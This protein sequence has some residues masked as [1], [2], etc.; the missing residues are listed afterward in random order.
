MSNNELSIIAITPNLGIEIKRQEIKKRV[1]DRLTELNLLDQKFKNNADILLLVCNLV[2]FM[3]KDKK[4]NKK[5]I[6][7]DIITTVYNN[8]NERALYD[9]NIEF[10]HS[11]KPIKKL[12]K[13]YLFCVGLYEYLFKSK[14]KP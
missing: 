12:S 11:T 14:K 6:V 3:V 8:P 5:E 4:I 1:I 2:E 13:F 10:L 7:L 9:S